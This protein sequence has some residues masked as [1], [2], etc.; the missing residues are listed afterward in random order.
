[1]SFDAERD[2]PH[3]QAIPYSV[4]RWVEE[5]EHLVL[6]SRCEPIKCHG[7]DASSCWVC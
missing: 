4:T 3:A 1:M 2:V 7:G 5:A 6:R